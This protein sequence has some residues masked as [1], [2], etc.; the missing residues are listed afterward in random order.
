MYISRD[1]YDALVAER[2]ALKQELD[3]MKA[4]S[5]SSEEE[6]ASLDS[7]KKAADDTAAALSTE[8]ENLRKSADQKDQE[9]A[10]LKA[11]NAELK[12]LPGAETARVK[13][14]KEQPDVTEDKAD[15]ATSED[16]SFIDNV[17]A[18]KERYL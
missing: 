7:A 16:K 13:A 10:S 11:E 8:N 2:D 9:I 17:R 15:L 18:S 5:K 14:D 1:K 4:E 12:K 3:T 6:F